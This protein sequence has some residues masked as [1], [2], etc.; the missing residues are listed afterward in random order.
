MGLIKSQHGVYIARKKV[1]K[2]LEEAVAKILDT[3]KTRQSWLKRSL[4]TKDPREANIRA[5]PVLIVFR[6]GIRTPY[7]G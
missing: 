3:G 5:K 4:G 7:S 1:P 6:H 2:G